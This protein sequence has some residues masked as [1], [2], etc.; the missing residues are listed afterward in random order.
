MR[1]LGEGFIP[2]RDL[3]VG[4]VVKVGKFCLEDVVGFVRL[5]SIR[6]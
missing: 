5:L 1:S 2:S 6:L 4:D 3:N